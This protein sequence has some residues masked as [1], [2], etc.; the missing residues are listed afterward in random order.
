MF[1]ARTDMSSKVRFRI[2]HGEGSVG[3][4]PTG[5]D[6]STFTCSTC[7]IDR[8]HERSFGSIYKW[9]ERNLGVNAE[10]QVLTVQ[11]VVS[12]STEGY[13]WELM[14]IRNTADWR[15]Y[16][17]YATTMAWPPGMLVQVHE[18]APAVEVEEDLEI[19][20]AAVNEEEASHQEAHMTEPEAHMTEPEAHIIEAEAQ[21]E[22]D[23]GE[24][25]PSIV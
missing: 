12:W 25:V 23:E 13:F 24:R 6:L 14:Y 3:S 10:T 11:T 19:I 2:F 16:M 1:G 21:G 5:V 18:K 15:M 4:G 9:L 8:P 22:A 7:G 20:P 17:E